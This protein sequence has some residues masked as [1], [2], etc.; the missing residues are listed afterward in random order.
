MGRRPFT[1]IELLVV[2]AI[3]AILAS[4]LLP[5]LNRARETAQAIK[6]TGNFKQLGTANVMYADSFGGSC[7]PVRLKSTAFSA[8]WVLNLTYLQGLGINAESVTGAGSG[9]VAKNDTAPDGMLCPGSIAAQKTKLLRNSYSIQ[10]TGFDDDSGV[11]FWGGQVI[12]SYQLSR[13]QSP[14]D[15][16]L[17][18]ESANW[19][20][21]YGT[22]NPSSTNGYWT[23]GEKEGGY[24]CVTYRHDGQQSA[25]VG[26]FDGHVAKLNWRSLYGGD[27]QKSKWRPYVANQ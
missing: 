1:L 19:T 13:T 16:Y 8:M 4:M 7:V 12:A 18:M 15:K 10:N 5:A 3:I 2:I 14:S 11:D 23:I 22:S 20:S 6:C 26:F 25:N 9:I 17:F 24:S 21:D 27:S